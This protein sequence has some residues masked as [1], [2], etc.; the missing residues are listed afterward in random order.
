MT[1]PNIQRY[2]AS[3]I[4]T[5]ILVYVFLATENPIA[6]GAT[7]SLL[8]ILFSSI[9]NDGF[10]PV[11][12]ITMAAMDK[13]PVNDVLPFIIAQILGGL[14]AYQLFRRVK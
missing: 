11:F 2:L 9:T 3:F 4:G 7:L 1:N 8:F 6:I 12:V 14:V 13:I 5:T 10:N